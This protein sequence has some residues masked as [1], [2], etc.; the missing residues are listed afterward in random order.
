MNEKND[1][2]IHNHQGGIIRHTMNYQPFDLLKKRYFVGGQPPVSYSSRGGVRC[3]SDDPTNLAGDEEWNDFRIGWKSSD[4]TATIMLIRPPMFRR[5]MMTNELKMVPHEAF[6][7]SQA[8]TK[9]KTTNTYYKKKPPDECHK[10]ATNPNFVGIPDDFPVTDT[11]QYYEL[12]DEDGVYRGDG[13]QVSKKGHIFFPTVYYAS[14]RG[15]TMGCHRE[16]LTPET[17]TAH[18]LNGT[19][20]ILGRRTIYREKRQCIFC[21]YRYLVRTYNITFSFDSDDYR[22]YFTGSDCNMESGACNA[23]LSVIILTALEG[24]RPK[25]CIAHHEGESWDN[26]RKKLAWITVG[27]NH[28]KVNLDP[29]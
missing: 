27:E 17:A 5:M 15:F 8:W 22:R 24:P 28:M 12:K 9:D 11:A 23:A 29:E 13:Y 2:T 20:D 4:M 26:D 21:E 3:E 10:F 14:T 7:Q 19:G 25:G 18:L 16:Y 6:Y 1:T